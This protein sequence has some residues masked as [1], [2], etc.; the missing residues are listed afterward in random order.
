MTENLLFFL[1]WSNGFF[2]TSIP[3]SF[4]SAR[5]SVT[6]VPCRA[7]PRERAER[8]HLCD[9]ML[10]H[11]ATK[12]RSN[13]KI[14]SYLSWRGWYKKASLLTET[15]YHS[16]CAAVWSIFLLIRG[17]SLALLA[18]GP[19]GFGG[20]RRDTFHRG[21]EEDGLVWAQWNAGK[22][23]CRSEIKYFFSPSP[24]FPGRELWEGH[25]ARA[26]IGRERERDCVPNATLFPL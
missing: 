18:S 11:V 2:A 4:D 23:I 5:L 3:F 12:H 10:F 7:V 21:E 16:I 9:R 20:R 22:S 6:A 24:I 17:S 14:A 25:R 15:Y 26:V 1:W 8:A 19:C 13:R